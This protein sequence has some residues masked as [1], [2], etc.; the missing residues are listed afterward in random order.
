MY[1]NYQFF[2]FLIINFWIFLINVICT[3]HASPQQLKNW[4]TRWFM[5]VYNNYFWVSIVYNTSL[6]FTREKNSIYMQIFNYI[7][8]GFFNYL[9]WGQ[10]AFRKYLLKYDGCW[11]KLWSRQILYTSIVNSVA[12]QRKWT[13]LYWKNM[14]S[15]LLMANF[16]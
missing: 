6:I 8:I 12:S 7:C 3:V 13:V 15:S 5:V 4:N 14:C 9:L 2:F 1:N 16:D 11:T 10:W